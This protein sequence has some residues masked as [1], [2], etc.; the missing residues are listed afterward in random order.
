MSKMARRVYNYHPHTGEFIDI[1]DPIMCPL[2]PGV[3]LVPAHATLIAPPEYDAEKQIAIFSE[4]DGA[5][6]IQEKPAPPPPPLVNWEQIRNERNGRLFW[7]DHV[8]VLDSPYSTE[9]KEAWRTY[10]QELRDLPKKFADAKDMDAV[11]WPTPP[12]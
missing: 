9:K 5:W 12:H 2:E 4:A 8:F 6:A 10:R 3:I 11:I 1:S 7:S